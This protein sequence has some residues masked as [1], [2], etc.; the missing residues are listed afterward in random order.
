M[1]SSRVTGATAS[2]FT[3]S[4]S[5]IA[6]DGTRAVSGL[7]AMYS[8]DSG[9]VKTSSAEHRDGHESRAPRSR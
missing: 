1:F 8:V 7:D 9:P 3:A 6:E 2:A 4:A 5:S